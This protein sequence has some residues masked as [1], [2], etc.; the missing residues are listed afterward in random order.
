MAAYYW[1]DT[2][3]YGGVPSTALKGGTDVDGDEIYVGRAFHEGDLIPAKVIPAKNVAYVA[4][5]GQ[6]VAKDCFQVLCE[7]RFKWVF[8]RGGEIPPGAVQGGHTSDGEPLY[9]GRVYYSESFTVG[10]V[11]PSH[12]CLYI[13]FNCEEKS[14]HE[15]ETLVLES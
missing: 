8:T 10:K 5:G 3:V 9:I 14:F 12:G 13:P 4:Y 15:F 2:S 6:E 7:Q 1:V 11:H